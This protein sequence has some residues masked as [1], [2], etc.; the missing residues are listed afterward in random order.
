M[1]LP[2]RPRRRAGLAH[3]VAAASLAG[4][5]A[6]AGIPSSHL[7]GPQPKP[8]TAYQTERSFAAPA[9]DWPS[10]RWWDAYGDT[11]LSGLIDEALKGSPTLAQAV[12]RLQSAEAQTEQARAATLPTITGEG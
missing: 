7:G 6:C 4:L 12:A 8:V 3:A 10:D 9:T 11:Q 5:A 1:P 2:L